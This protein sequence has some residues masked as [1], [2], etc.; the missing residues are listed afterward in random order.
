[1]M[2]S[3]AAKS[4]LAPVIRLLQIMAIIM[5]PMVYIA[6]SVKLL[7]PIR[8]FNKLNIPCLNSLILSLYSQT[9]CLST[10]THNRFFG[11]RC[12][13]RTNVFSFGKRRPTISRTGRI[14]NRASMSAVAVNTRLVE[15]KTSPL[16]PLLSPV[17]LYTNTV[18]QDGIQV[19]R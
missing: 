6:A 15:T 8:R 17:V 1:M 16:Q 9:V 19:H 12:W 13:N 4:N 5:C 14:I 10:Q 18:H 11:C 3:I 7:P 2:A